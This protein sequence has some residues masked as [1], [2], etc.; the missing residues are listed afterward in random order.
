MRGGLDADESDPRFHQQMVYGV[1]MKT[2]E[3]FE[4]A[5]VGA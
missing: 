3:L 5:R 1:A 4:R 2:V